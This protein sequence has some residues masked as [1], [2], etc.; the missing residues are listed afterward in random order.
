[1]IHP[2]FQ[3]RNGSPVALERAIMGKMSQPPGSWGVRM[4]KVSV[5][6]AG[7]G[8][9][10]LTLARDLARRGVD[11]MLVERNF[12]TTRHPKMDNTNVRSMELFGLAGLEP[13]LR[14]VA[15][16]EDHPFDV[17][18]VTRMTGH[19][20]KR[21]CYRSPLEDRE[22][23]RDRNDGSQP[24]SPA[25]RVSQAKIEPVLKAAL[26]AEH[27][28]DI[29]FGVAVV[30]V[31]EDADGVTVTLRDQTSGQTEQVR[32]L[33]LAGC[34]GGGSTVRAAV[35]IGVTGQHSIMPR[36]MTHFRTDDAEARALLQRWGVTW[37]Y[38][39]IHGTLI[40]QNDVDTWTLHTR[41]PA[42]ERDAS[43]P[44]ALI[45]RFVGKAIP[46]EILIANPW[47]PHLLVAEAARTPRVFLAGDAAHQYIP[48]GG[49]GMNTGIGDAYTLGWQLAAVLAGFGGPALLR[50][51]Q[52]E[53]HPIWQRNLEGSRRHNA[54]RVEIASLYEAGLEDNGDAGAA[55]RAAAAERIAAL[56]NA[57]NESLG[58]EL[59]YHYTGSPIVASE[60]G[61]KA[62][63][64]PYRYQPNTLP[65]ARLPSVFLDDGTAVYA[66]LG[67]WFTCIAFRGTDTTKIEEAARCRVIPLTV[68][69]FDD[70]HVR[71][72]YGADM[73]L[74]RPDQHVAWRG[75][76]LAESSDAGAVLAT[77]L[78]W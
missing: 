72:I 69:R 20:L 7:G 49:Y 65:G 17:S 27:N 23:F 70:P 78:G 21:F 60:A 5:L 30:D 68:L 32:C 14:A 1:M 28:V 9:V 39:S 8:P 43:E 62:P 40:A 33:F 4:K 11:C 41:Y 59:G 3:F 56:G 10:G 16:P 66:Q 51:Y 75:T 15:V 58:L 74:V 34:D 18:W 6:V 64:D 24:F 44:G 52:D 13:R 2:T 67:R 26:E 19:E 54:V 57:E 38:Q 76:G 47:S 12:T 53:R 50:A 36:F 55:A 73:L 25:M 61:A 46:H 37:H 63:D 71:E 29:R 42:N 45:E 77:A 35:G 31:A 48:T 22:H